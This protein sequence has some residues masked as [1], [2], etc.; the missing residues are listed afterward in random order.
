MEIIG[1]VYM[2]VLGVFEIM[3]YYVFN[4]CNMVLDMIVLMV[5]FF[6][7]FIGGYMW[8]CVGKKNL[9]FLINLVVFFSVFI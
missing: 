2:V 9:N 8:I 4:I 7:F 1:D 6:D 3:V 5:E